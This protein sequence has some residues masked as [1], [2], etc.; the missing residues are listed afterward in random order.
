MLVGLE[1]PTCGSLGFRLPVSPRFIVRAAAS[2]VPR[3]PSDLTRG[4][5]ERGRG[6]GRTGGI[7]CVSRKG[8]DTSLRCRIFKSLFIL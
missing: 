7:T 6:G 5:T 1:A 4:G 2:W 3:G 8:L